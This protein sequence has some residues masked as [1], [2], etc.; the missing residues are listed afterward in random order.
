VL[1]PFQERKGEDEGG[2]ARASVREREGGGLGRVGQEDNAQEEWGGAGRLKAKAQV[3][4]PKTGDGPK[5]KR[6][7]LSNFKLKLVIWLD[8]GNLHK[9]I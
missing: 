1:R 6:K 5:L 4:G 2:G 8:F 9:E 3:T 7:F